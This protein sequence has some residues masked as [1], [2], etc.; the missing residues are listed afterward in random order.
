MLYMVVCI[1]N[2][3]LI[4]GVCACLILVTEESICF[5]YLEKQILKYQK[6]RKIYSHIYLHILR[7]GFAKNG[8]FFLACGK[9]QKKNTSRKDLF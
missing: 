2:A 4:P 7:E 1:E 6:F 8:H 5:L 3:F 9:R